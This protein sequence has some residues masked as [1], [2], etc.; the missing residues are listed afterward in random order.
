LLNRESGT[1]GARR[2]YVTPLR[3]K[4][5]SRTGGKWFA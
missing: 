2:M 5:M 1:S 3:S 4:I